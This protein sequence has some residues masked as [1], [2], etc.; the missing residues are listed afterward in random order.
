LFDRVGRELQLDIHACPSKVAE[1]I[2]GGKII[3]RVTAASD[4]ANEPR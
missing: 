3:A 1:G 2:G 4:A